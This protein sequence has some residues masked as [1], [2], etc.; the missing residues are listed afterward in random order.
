MNVK[1]LVALILLVLGYSF[2]LAQTYTFGF[3]DT[4]GNLFCNYEQLWV[5][6]GALVTG[7]DNLS[8]CGYPN[9]GYLLGMQGKF[10]AGPTLVTSGAALNDNSVEVEGGCTGI[11]VLLY[12][13]LKCNKPDKNGKYHGKYGWLNVAAV[14]GFL[15][16]SDY[17]YLSC[18]IPSKGDGDALMRGTT[19]GNLREKL[20]K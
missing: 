14:S 1:S 19:W 18:T 12:T 6:S 9:N 2:A 10:P 8:A 20:K 7:T 3:V 17:G 15:F 4:N 11:Q 16:G 13:A 5:D